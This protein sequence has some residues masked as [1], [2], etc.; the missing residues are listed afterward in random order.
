MDIWRQ[1][2]GSGATE[3]CGVFVRAVCWGCLVSL[4]G[5]AVCVSCVI[6]CVARDFLLLMYA[7]VHVSFA[8]AADP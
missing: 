2:S 3:M 5:L 4:I 6:Q 1:G 7:H 8:L